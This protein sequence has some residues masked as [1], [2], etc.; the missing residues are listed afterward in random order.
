MVAVVGKPVSDRSG[1]VA[2]LPPATT[3]RP[4]LKR[5]TRVQ[6]HHIAECC[7]AFSCSNLGTSRTRM[8]WTICT[9]PLRMVMKLRS[10][11]VKAAIPVHRRETSFHISHKFI[12]IPHLFGIARVP[13]SAPPPK[14]GPGRLR[15]VILPLLCRLSHTLSPHD[16]HDC[17]IHGSE[18]CHMQIMES[19]AMPRPSCASISTNSPAC[20]HGESQLAH[21]DL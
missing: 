19:F 4:Q 12:P 11:K 15:P 3:I 2:S 9:K 20:P 18:Q 13:M 1:H 17:S 21:K 8:K 5:L 16:S 10:M 6:A 7:C 14:S